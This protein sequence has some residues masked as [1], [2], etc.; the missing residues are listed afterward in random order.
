MSK[1][2]DELELTEEQLAAID[3]IRANLRVAI[4]TRHWI[5]RNLFLALFDRMGAPTDRF[6][7]STGKLKI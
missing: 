7:D 5:A 3:E 4:V 1:Q 2:A 6:G